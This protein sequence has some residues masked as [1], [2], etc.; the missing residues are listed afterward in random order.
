MISGLNSANQEFVDN[1]RRITDRLNTDQLQIASGLRL[2]DV[3][4]GP[5]QVSE[6][7]QARAA[8]AASQQVSSNLG[9]VKSEVDM[10]EQTLESAVQLFDQVQT[11]GA[12]GATGTQTAAA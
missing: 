6:L 10:G 4:D 1:L 12:E 7:L 9:N 8:L 3:S 2:R 5:D 11:L